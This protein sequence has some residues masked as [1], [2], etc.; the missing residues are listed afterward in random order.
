MCHTKVCQTR[1]WGGGVFKILKAAYFF[2]MVLIAIRVM[3][4]KIKQCITLYQY[5]QKI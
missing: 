4:N 1:I 2:D 5:F 3:K